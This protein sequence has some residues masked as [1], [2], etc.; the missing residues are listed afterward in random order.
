MSEHDDLRVEQSV[1]QALA[2]RDPGPAPV[3]LRD[4]VARV[5]EAATARSTGM[6][7]LARVGVPLLGLAAAILLLMI[8]AP[9]LAPRGVGPGA[10]TE[11]G[12]SFDPSLKGPGLVAPPLVEAEGLVVLGLLIAGAIVLV[13]APA[14][15]R[16][17]GAA[18]VALV[19]LGFGGSQVLLTHAITGPVAS[20]G[21]IGVLNVEQTEP[22][23]GPYPVYI[24]AAP[25]EPFTFGFSVQNEGP[26]PIRVEGVVADPLVQDGLVF[27][28]TLRAVW[29]AGPVNPDAAFVPPQAPFSP[30]DLGSGSWVALWLVETASPCAAGPQYDPA[31]AADTAYV[32][33]PT[34]RVEYSVLGFPRTT[35]NNL[36]FDLLQPY[37][38]NCPPQP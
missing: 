31:D 18:V 2:R 14:G 12:T 25:G 21:G 29:S 30:V 9:L 37:L 10:S 19:V 15:P 20:S 6:R 1:R 35:E 5:P 11:P 8:A 13:A 4:R 23:G 34:V 17:A 16:R 26:L 22:G 32:G 7:R 38:A 36:P 33:I 24:T 27:Y 28:P 3:A